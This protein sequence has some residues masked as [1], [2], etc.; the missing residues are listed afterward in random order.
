MEHL[1]PPEEEV[2]YARR[3]WFESRQQEFASA[4]APA[5]S[6]QSAALTLDL[7]ACFC[8]G[9]WAAVV[10]LAAVVVESQAEASKRRRAAPA[11]EL[12]WLRALRNR[13]LH[14]NRAAPAITI[15]DQWT[16]RGPWEKNAR[17]AVSIAFQVMYARPADPPGGGRDATASRRLQDD[18]S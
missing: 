14:E 18:R 4:G 17:R 5:V 6:E 16:G 15:E 10:I 12:R 3:L 13:L 11:G 9:A 8:A 7:Q 2:W 1:E